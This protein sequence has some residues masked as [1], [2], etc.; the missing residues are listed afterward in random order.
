MAR[1]KF[2]IVKLAN[3]KITSMISQSIYHN[4]IF[5]YIFYTYSKINMYA[6]IREIKQKKV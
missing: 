2:N 6:E 3:M 1:G 5:S 4:S